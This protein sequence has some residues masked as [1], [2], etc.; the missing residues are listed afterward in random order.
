MSSL[1]LETR[2]KE[3]DLLA[4]HTGTSDSVLDQLVQGYNARQI[5][6]KLVLAGVKGPE[7]ARLVQEIAAEC[8][9]T[10]R[11]DRH[12][13]GR[14]KPEAPGRQRPCRRRCGRGRGGSLLL[15]G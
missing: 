9:S 14:R 4:I 10:I 12:R 15:R 1:G 13:A 2:L 6:E 5:T 3:G 11:V 8:D 7:A